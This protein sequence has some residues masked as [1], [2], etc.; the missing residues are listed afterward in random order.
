[1][2]VRRSL[3]AAL[4]LLVV[5]V[6]INYIDRGNLSVA[7]PLLKSELKI[8]E[9]QLGLL[10]SS[11]FWTYAACQFLAGWLVDHYNANWILAIGFVAWSV[12]TAATG[13][14]GGFASL[15]VLRLLVGIGESVAYPAY[16]K[17]FATHYA[18]D[19]RGWANSLIDV[20]CKLGPAL[21]TLV[22]GVVMAKIGW[23]P[24]FVVLGFGA[25]VWVPL[26]IKWMPRGRGI[27]TQD[28]RVKPGF[29]EIICHRSAW[30]T[31]G[32]LICSNYYWYFMLTW[33]PFYLVKERHFSMQKMGVVGAL[34]FIFTAAATTLAG[35]IS[36]RAIASG[37]TP[38][39]VRKI[40]TSM[41]L[42]IGTVIVFVPMI[43][44][45]VG[46]MV[47]LMIAS[48]GY[49]IYTTSH[50]AITQ[51]IA[52]PL[53]VGRWTGLQNGIGNLSGAAAPWLTGLVL[54]KTGHFQWA[55]VLT[56]AFAL[57]G[58]CIYLFGLGEVVPAKW[59]CE[60]AVI[61]VSETSDD[62]PVRV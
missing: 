16:S 42:G 41:G 56:A 17:I 49:G 46:A 22:G 45:N 58:A 31:V 35:W 21:G 39:R 26:W 33:M 40:C 47:V 61:E 43:H 7:A 18:E 20:G 27:V 29:L 3:W 52:G 11:F 12:A 48:F 4:F 2:A 57:I 44:N 19:Q 15:L 50:W 25:L 54:E 1:M 53:A 23:R 9:Y 32:G 55:F 6:A 14:V 8:S 38:T 28:D 37:S 5:S 24:F 10:L 36:Y 62:D 13:L 59:R 51:T 34:P 30:A 60:L